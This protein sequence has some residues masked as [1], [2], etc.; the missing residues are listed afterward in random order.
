ML[1]QRI[2]R[3]AAF[4][5]AVAAPAVAQNTTRDTTICVCRTQRRHEPS[6]FA[7]R[8]SG[9]FAFTQSR[10]LG[11]LKDNIGFGYGASAAYMFRLDRAG[12]LSLR[13][14]LAL[15]DYGHESMRVPL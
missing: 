8:S 7:R 4:G 5:L 10:P 11:G 2:G 6:E 12:V 3:A 15:V 9:S 13:T 1:V 14:D